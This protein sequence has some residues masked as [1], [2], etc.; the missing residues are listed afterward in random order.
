[1]KSGDL[2]AGVEADDCFVAYDFRA[3]QARIPLSAEGEELV[4]WILNWEFFEA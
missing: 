3:M 2:P 1:V 4:E